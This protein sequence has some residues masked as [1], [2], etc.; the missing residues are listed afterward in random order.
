MGSPESEG[1]GVTSPYTDD[2][3]LR[4]VENG[5]SNY[6]NYRW[7][8]DA[9]IPWAH[10]L[11]R[12][13]NIKESDR[14]LDVGCALAMYVKA[15]RFI[16]VDAYGYDISE[17]AIANCHPDVKSFISNHLNGA[18]FDLIYSKDCFEHVPPMEL[19]QL[20]KYLLAHTH[21]LFIIVP[22]SH[23]K[24]GGYVHEKEERDSTHVNRWPLQD[25]IEF[26]GKCSSS[27]ITNGSFMYPGLKPGAYEVEHGYG[28]I[29]ATKI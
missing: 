4:G 6:T 19:E 24:G 22:L 11:R 17:W 20:V 13:L 12:L 25:W 29:L 10:T 18:N 28:F 23:E 9:T 2:Y 27:F 1:G 14:V 21:R 7:V 5:L 3:Y 26:I 15:L 8:P 16:G